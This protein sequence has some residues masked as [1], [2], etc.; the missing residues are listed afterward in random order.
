MTCLQL[1]KFNCSNLAQPKLPANATLSN[2]WFNSLTGVT[3]MRSLALLAK[4]ALAR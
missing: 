2:K 3:S 1:F 4:S